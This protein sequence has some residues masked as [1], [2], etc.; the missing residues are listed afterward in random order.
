[1]K[2]EKQ[3]HL[4][5]IAQSESEVNCCNDELEDICE[6]QLRLKREMDGPRDQLFARGEEEAVIADDAHVVTDG[7]NSKTDSES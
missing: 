2:S 1:M 3:R 5:Q 6:N 4:E 7:E